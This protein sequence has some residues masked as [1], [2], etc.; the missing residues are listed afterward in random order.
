MRKSAQSAGPRVG[1]QNHIGT[2]FHQR[3]H[4]DEEPVSVLADHGAVPDGARGKSLGVVGYVGAQSR[5][6][7]L[8]MIFQRDAMCVGPRAG[9]QIR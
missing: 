1:W 4:A 8:P 2:D 7:D 3:E 9:K 6:R 5:Q